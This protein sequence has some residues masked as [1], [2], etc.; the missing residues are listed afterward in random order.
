L[1]QPTYQPAVVI[2]CNTLRL[3]DYTQHRSAACGQLSVSASELASEQEALVAMEPLIFDQERIK[4]FDAALQALLSVRTS[5]CGKAVDALQP[6]QYSS[7]MSPGHTDAPGNEYTA[8][9]K[10]FEATSV[11]CMGRSCVHMP[12]MCWLTS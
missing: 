5:Y 6:K 8:Y 3:F 7:N 11:S 12:S 10:S 1:E 2:A 4:L 9:I